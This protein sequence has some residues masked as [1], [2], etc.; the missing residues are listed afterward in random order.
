GRVTLNEGCVT[1]SHHGTAGSSANW[2][3]ARGRSHGLRAWSSGKGRRLVVRGLDG[4]RNEDLDA[5][6]APSDLQ[7]GEGRRGGVQPR[8][9]QRSVVAEHAHVAWTLQPSGF[10]IPAE[11]AALV[12]A[13]AGHCGEAGASLG[14]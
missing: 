6:V 10:V 5:A 7:P 12:R 13:H 11:Q 4:W 14:E 9:D 3:P 2:L 8:A 1:G